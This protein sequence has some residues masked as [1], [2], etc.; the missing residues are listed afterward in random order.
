MLSA[1]VSTRF[2]V[3]FNAIS[4]DVIPIT[5]NHSTY[6]SVSEENNDGI[7]EPINGE[8]AS[9]RE[10]HWWDL[11]LPGVSLLITD[12]FRLVECELILDIV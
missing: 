2:S 3:N 10:T 7:V 6:L 8:S 12:K 1:F 5:W 4:H 9:I 11:K